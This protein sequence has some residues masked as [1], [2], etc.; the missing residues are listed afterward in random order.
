[1]HRGASLSACGEPKRMGPAAGSY[2]AQRMRHG[3]WDDIMWDWGRTNNIV[4]YS[5][6]D[7]AVFLAAALKC[8]IRCTFL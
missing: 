5:N 8:V 4:E 2:T 1:M 6:K 7:A 3:N